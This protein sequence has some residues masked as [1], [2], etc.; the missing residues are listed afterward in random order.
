M[1]DK[2]TA[3]IGELIFNVM[4]ST[5]MNYFRNNYKKVL[6]WLTSVEGFRTSGERPLFC[7]RTFDSENNR[8]YHDDPGFWLVLS[9]LRDS[10][11]EPWFGLPFLGLPFLLHHIQSA[12]RPVSHC[13][14][15]VGWSFCLHSP[16][17][18]WGYEIEDTRRGFFLHLRLP[19]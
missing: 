11:A 6:V 7:R 9:G 19:A 10:Q 18:W 14:P 1:K 8:D 15:C 5:L 4:F 2:V 13:T 16:C 12:S 17:Q 3:R